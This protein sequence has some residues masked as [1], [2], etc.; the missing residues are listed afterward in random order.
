M[1]GRVERK[2]GDGKRRFCCVINSSIVFQLLL[3]L[4]SFLLF[5]RKSVVVVLSRRMLLS[6]GR[7]VVV[8]VLLSFVEDPLLFSLPVV[9]CWKAN[10]CC[11]CLLFMCMCMCVVVQWNGTFVVYCN[12]IQWN[13]SKLVFFLNYVSNIL[14][15]KR[16]LLDRFSTLLFSGKTEM[17]EGVQV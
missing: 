5:S 9:V 4:S 6:V 11:C 7:S 13:F 1:K 17:P 3:L 10:S 12:F 8:F 16:Q 15:G 2:G 14:K